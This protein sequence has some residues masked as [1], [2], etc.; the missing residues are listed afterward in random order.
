MY[1]K[2]LTMVRLH[3]EFPLLKFLQHMSF[4]KKKSIIFKCEKLVD[5]FILG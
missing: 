2:G 3:M 1:S 4:M 5:E